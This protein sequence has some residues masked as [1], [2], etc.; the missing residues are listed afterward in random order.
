MA[1]LIPHDMSLCIGTLILLFW[2]EVKRT[3][4]VEFMIDNDFEIIFEAFHELAQLGFPIYVII[5]SYIYAN[6]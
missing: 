2:A 1:G 3:A 5:I 4:G 6:N